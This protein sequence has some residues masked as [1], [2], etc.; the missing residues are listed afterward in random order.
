MKK[1]PIIL[2]LL[3]LTTLQAQEYKKQALD[4]FLCIGQSNMAGMSPI[5]EKDRDTLH[6]TYLLNDKNQW[7]KAICADEALNKYST[8]KKEKPQTLGVSYTFA[9]KL[10]NYSK[11]PLGIVANARSG[12]KIEWWLKGYEGDN[13]FDMYEEAVLKVKTALAASPDSKVKGII[14]HQGEGDNSA[15]N[16]A[17]YM[18]RL[19]K[20][21][22]D[23]RSAIGDQTIPFIV[24]EVGKWKGRGKGI[25]PVLR[26]VKEG[27]PYTDWVSSDGLTSLNIA[28]NDPHFD[29]F[30]QRALGSRYADKVMEMVY[31]LPAGGIT[32]FNEASY[33]G[34]SVQLKAGKYT[35][36]WLE[37]MG[38]TV[39]EIASIKV[40]KGYETT[41]QSAGK[42][43]QKIT[44]SSAQFKKQVFD[45]L[46]VA[47]KK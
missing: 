22:S 35:P 27:I 5:L 10:E 36:D 32:F 4:I 34:R 18:E 11:N 8:V 13:D 47:Y 25:N 20:L 40:D 28:K 46:Q 7:E 19:N 21:V 31:N 33:E 43:V 1:L 12:T 3:C 14:W 37:K 41:L 26:Q 45:T 15:P 23:L 9:R 16:S 29:N 44:K 42:T 30:S 2:C 39:D 17:I 38:I 6:H 24:G